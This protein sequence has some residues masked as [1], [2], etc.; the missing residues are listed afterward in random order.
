MLSLSYTSRLTNS[1]RQAALCH[2]LETWETEGELVR[3]SGQ[4]WMNGEGIDTSPVLRLKCECGQTIV[5]VSPDYGHNVECPTCNTDHEISGDAYY[6]F[7]INIQ[8]FDL[9]RQTKDLYGAA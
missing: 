8:N 6:Q 9:Y 1:E 4:W 7:G 3:E 2:L 5:F